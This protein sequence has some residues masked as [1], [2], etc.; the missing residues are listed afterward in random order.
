MIAILF[1]K[2]GAIVIA[3]PFEKVG[4]MAIALLWRYIFFFEVIWNSLHFYE[5]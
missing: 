3:I 5:K 2:V 4:E 1:E